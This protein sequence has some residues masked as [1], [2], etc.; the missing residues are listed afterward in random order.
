MR[1]WILLGILLFA[2]FYLVSNRETI[3]M[4]H[5][6]APP[7]VPVPV[8]AST[9]STAEPIA[10]KPDQ[11]LMKLAAKMTKLEAELKEMKDTSAA[12]MSQ[13][14]AAQASLQSIR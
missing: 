11:E 10:P 14:S 1:Y 5:L 3:I 2:V 12:Q 7:T 8:P 9:P 4:E 13:A 6:T